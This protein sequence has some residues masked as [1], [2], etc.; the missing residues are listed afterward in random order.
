[1]KGYGMKVTI[2]IDVTDCRDCHFNRYHSGHGEC[3]YY[4]SHPYS[5][6]GYDD[7]L[8]GCGEKF[9]EIPNW[10]PLGLREK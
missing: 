7:I 10:C 8:Y 5:P 9:K 6:D 3:W 1:M 2:E 4:C